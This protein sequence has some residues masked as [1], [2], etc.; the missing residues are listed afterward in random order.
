MT[1]NLRAIALDGARPILVQY[2]DPFQA[3]LFPGR[4]L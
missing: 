2:T 1:D 3:L 4:P